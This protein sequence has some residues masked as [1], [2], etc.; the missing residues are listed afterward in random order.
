MSVKI[1]FDANQDFQSEAV[2][3]IIDLFGGWSRAPLEPR[4]NG[5]FIE[6]GD[7]LLPQSFVSNN[8]GIDRETLISNIKQIQSRTRTDRVGR[9]KNVIPEQLRIS[10]DAPDSL[11]DFSVEMETGTGKTYVYL[12]TVL[13]LYRRYR[14]SKFIIVVPSI[15]IR[16]GVLGSLRLM[17]AHFKDLYP[18][19]QYDSYV[20]S[21]KNLTKIR[22]FATSNHLQI[23]VMNIQAFN[24]SDNLI[25]RANETMND[26]A[27]IEFITAVNPVVIMDEPQKLNGPKHK[28]AIESLNPIF[29]L[30][31]SATHK[32]HHCLLYRLSP[33]DAYEM[34]LVKQIEVLSLSS[35]DDGASPY[36]E[37]VRI[38]A[39]KSGVKATVRLNMPHAPKTNKVVTRNSSLAEITQS[40]I[41]KGWSVEEIVPERDNAAGYV[42]F[43][44]GRRLRV[45]ETTDTDQDWWQRAQIQAAI[46]A[47]MRTELRLQ[48]K[49]NTNEIEP[50]KPLTLFFID[51]VANYYPSDG[52][53]RLW[54]EEIYEQ[55]LKDREFRNLDFVHQKHPAASVH[56]GYF[57]VSK[58]GE[59]KDTNGETV[60]DKTAYDLIMGNK[61]KLL[62]FEEPVRFI[63]SHSALQE[64]W[65][66]PNV[67]TICNLQENIKKEDTRR[68]QIGRGLRLPVMANGE[69][70]KVG[71]VNVLTVV[72][73]ESFE[74]FASKL[75]ME[76]EN[77]TGEKFGK[78]NIKNARE[79]KALQIR[80][81]VLESDEFQKLWSQISKKTSY[82]LEFTTEDI[83]SEAS[84]RL[85]N[86]IHME[87][88][89]APKVVKS[90]NKLR[91]KSGQ[92]IGSAGGP[93]SRF[94]DVE[95]A[96]A[97]PDIMSDLARQLPISRSSI[98]RVIKE[99][100]T[101]VFAAI[102]P[103]AYSER[104]RRACSQALGHT[105]RGKDGIYYYPSGQVWEA[106]LFSQ[107]SA[108]ESY[109]DNLISTAKSIFTEVPC[110]SQVERDFATALESDEEVHFFMKLP[111]WFKVP[112]PLGYYNPDWAVVKSEGD[113]EFLY[114]IRE[115]KGVDNPDDL[116][117]EAEKWKVAF[118]KKHFTS[119]NVD[120][121]ITKAWR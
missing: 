53:F 121:A 107:L 24:S 105:L 17:E 2:S 91:I 50:T 72:A 51:K 18:D 9:V 78:A 44:N 115:T 98:Y 1:Q 35:E 42:E 81:E 67:F 111:G 15:A 39:N 82:K 93:V 32:E 64:G 14:L 88:V 13:E 86:I 55:V 33:I 74:N 48:S 11:I 117:R 120:Y 59:A 71:Q 113:D 65:D 77:E 83:V 90:I 3:S 60:D 20:Y 21:S 87:P 30:R 68:Q 112:T 5:S 47:H 70:C 101:E 19:V 6:H 38:N 99:S 43:S 12:R 104:V 26:R 61:E 41:Y 16:E 37:V 58:K 94:V 63:F 85:R 95:R 118:G 89:V 52:K 8:W 28:E 110:D 22:Q 96:F 56:A 34:R 69:R 114:L 23:M 45:N 116:F 40:D 29:R 7:A 76:L 103:S 119:I 46:E 10:E 27:P 36:I 31:Y 102:N 4:S 80:P 54:F 100:K 92:D 109:S 75:Q 106:Q 49:A 66:N 25:L 73:S 62:S 97:V 84:F 108:P 79:R 57:S